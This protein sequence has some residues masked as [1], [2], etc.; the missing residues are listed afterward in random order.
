M[1]PVATLPQVDNLAILGNSSIKLTLVVPALRQ[2]APHNQD[3]LLRDNMGHR[4][5]RADTEALPLPSKCR[6]VQPRLQATSSFCKRVSKRRVFKT[7]IHQT[8]QC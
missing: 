4:P 8:P 1:L 7:F 2:V 6:P 3:N 5:N